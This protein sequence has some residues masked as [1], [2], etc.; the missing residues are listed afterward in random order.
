[1]V[2]WQGPV[3]VAM[4][5]RSTGVSLS[6]DEVVWNANDNVFAL[7]KDAQLGDVPRAITHVRGARVLVD[8]GSAYLSGSPMVKVDLQTGAD[9]TLYNA[10]CRHEIALGPPYVFCS[11][12]D[13]GVRR[14][15]L[16]GTNPSSVQDVTTEYTA[17]VVIGDFVYY[18]GLARQLLRRPIHLDMNAETIF[19]GAALRGGLATVNGHVYALGPDALLDIDIAG[20]TGTAIMETKGAAGMLAADARAIYVT[21]WGTPYLLRK[22]L[23]GG[24]DLTFTTDA[25]HTDVVVMD[26]TRVFFTDHTGNALY[27]LVR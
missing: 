12:Q 14:F 10:P 3:D 20:G 5:L 17:L 1:M 8:G 27:R 9:Q 16:D 21:Q 23:D 24:P 26:D 18:Q 7:P 15:A 6:S 22:S 25:R 4:T 2:I 19:V 11:D 13:M